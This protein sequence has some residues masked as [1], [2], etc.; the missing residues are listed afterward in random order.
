MENGIIRFTMGWKK[1]IVNNFLVHHNNQHIKLD[2]TLAA[3]NEEEFLV[4]L[5]EVNLDYILNYCRAGEKNPCF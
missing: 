1:L 4:D 5:S 3:G 2:G